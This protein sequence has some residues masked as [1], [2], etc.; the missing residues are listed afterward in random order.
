MGKEKEFVFFQP[1]NDHMKSFNYSSIYYI[2]LFILFMLNLFSIIFN[3][4][5]H[6]QINEKTGD[7]SVNHKIN[8]ICP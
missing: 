8:S 6:M 5:S 2:L 4:T 3:M 7:Y 1:S